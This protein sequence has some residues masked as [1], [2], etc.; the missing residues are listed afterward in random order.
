MS[1]ISPQLETTAT[2]GADEAVATVQPMAVP[3]APKPGEAW[4]AVIAATAAATK[5]A[6]AAMPEAS[7]ASARPSAAK[8][9]TRRPASSKPAAQPLLASLPVTA[10]KPRKQ[11]G[12]PAVARKPSPTV[13]RPVPSVAA[14]SVAKA[15]AKPDK[16]AKAPKL[17]KSA[18]AA[19]PAVSVQAKA[20]GKVKTKAKSPEL[21]A[22]KPL[23]TTPA[24]KPQREKE[25]LVRD[26][27]T[28]PHAD[29]V[30]IHQLK[31]RALGFKRATKK[32]E[33][34]RAGLQALASL[35]DAQLQAVLGKLTPIKAGRPKKAD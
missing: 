10:A 4:P 25:K 1:S 35:G 27:F 2:R 22:S 12:K 26:S 19:K 5:P 9:A 17:A 20:G 8:R 13:A 15:A 32:S 7:S 34:L 33:L 29:F 28:M 3:E 30:L 21:A 24:A 18:N 14:T 11:A 31:E 23:A 6:A 16:S